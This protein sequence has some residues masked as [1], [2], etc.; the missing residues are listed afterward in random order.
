MAVMLDGAADYGAGD[1]VDPAI[2][3]L[4]QIGAISTI[5]RWLR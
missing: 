1:G 4:A 5:T 3:F 2:N